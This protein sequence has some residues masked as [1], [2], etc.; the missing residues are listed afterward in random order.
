MPD[1]TSGEST[2]PTT[3]T[4]PR[5]AVVSPPEG[6]REERDADGVRVGD[7]GSGVGGE[8]R[9]QYRSGEQR[10]HEE[11]DEQVEK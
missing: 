11:A 5:A 3:G 8:R 10:A 9:V 6:E 1:Q 7:G 4:Q 2:A